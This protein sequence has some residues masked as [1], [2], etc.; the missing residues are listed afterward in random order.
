M[1]KNLLKIAFV[2]VLCA[3]LNVATL[4][5][6]KSRKVTFDT[7]VMVGDTLVKRGSYKVAFDEQSNVL[8][9]MDDK[10]VV[11]KIS[12]RLEEFKSKAEKSVAYRYWKNAKAEAVLSRVNLGSSYVSIGGDNAAAVSAP[13]AAGTSQQ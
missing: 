6:G 5:G 13:A 11:A 10:K 8:T 9:I 4:A 2:L 3:L 1:K 7:D 12:A